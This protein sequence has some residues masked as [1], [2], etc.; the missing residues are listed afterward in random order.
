[1][2]YT[3]KQKE[4]LEFVANFQNDKGYSPTLEEIANAFEI[5]RVT[6]FGH[7][8]ALEKKGAIRRKHHESRSAAI[9]DPK[10]SPSALTLPLLGVIQAGAPI[11]AIEVPEVFDVKAMVPIDEFHYVLKV[12]GTSMIEDGVRPGD[13]VIVRRTNLARNGQMVVAVL[14]DGEATLKRYFHEG[15][16][17]RLQPANEDMPPIYVNECEIRGIAVGIFR[18]F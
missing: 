6:V 15:D 17:I 9:L 12:K 11:E 3:K 14:D 8:K 10:Y 5:S 13:F 2:G 1:M 18:R 4:V 16:R 7:M